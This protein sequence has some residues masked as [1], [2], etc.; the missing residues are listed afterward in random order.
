M[1]KLT[2]KTNKV[3]VINIKPNNNVFKVASEGVELLRFDLK[4]E[5]V[6]EEEEK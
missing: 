6:I 4:G 5:L 3:G 1:D 2:V